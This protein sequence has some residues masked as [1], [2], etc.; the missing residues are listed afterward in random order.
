MLTGYHLSA[1][2]LSMYIYSIIVLGLVC[3]LAPHIKRQSPLQCLALAWIYIID[4]LINL[5]YTGVFGATWFILLA[6]HLTDEPV[7]SGPGGKM[8]NDTAGFTDPETNVS[9]V[10]VV[11]TPAPGVVPAQDAVA[12]GLHDGSALGNA[13]FQAGSIMS[14]SVISGLWL[15]RLYFVLI[16]MAYARGVLRQYILTT[17]ASNYGLQ[18][19]STSSDLA[20]NPFSAGREEGQGWKGKLGRAMTRVLQSYWLGKDDEDEWVRGAGDRFRKLAIKVP[21]P[22]VGERERRARSGTGP[23]PALALKKMEKRET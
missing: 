19:G 15:V 21:E 9:R 22:G 10:E 14:I 7:A 13:V 8:M 11:A 23:P 5:A 18:G 12:V 20:E 3:Y 17:S 1:V 4:S 6:R 16:V 2:Q